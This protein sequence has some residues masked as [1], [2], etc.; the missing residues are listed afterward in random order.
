MKIYGNTICADPEHD[1]GLENSRRYSEEAFESFVE[2]RLL[3][4][5]LSTL[6]L[7]PE[8]ESELRKEFMRT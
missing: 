2:W 7:D 6:D 3:I 5:E 8:V 1:W 4:G